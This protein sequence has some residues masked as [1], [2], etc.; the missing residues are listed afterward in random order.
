MAG[1]EILFSIV[2]VLGL[3]QLGCLI[4][5]DE[6][7]AYVHLWRWIGHVMGVAPELAP[8]N[9]REA[10]RHGELIDLTS[11]DPDDDS[12]ALVDAL[13]RS[14]EQSPSVEVRKRAGWVR[15]ILDALVHELVG[16]D[17]ATRL[18]VPAGPVRRAL[19]ALR[20]SMRGVEVLR[21]RSRA[22][23]DACVRQGQIYWARSI[24][25]GLGGLPLD[26]SAVAPRPA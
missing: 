1:T 26:L 21:R 4:E 8:A 9:A 22:V 20:A 17:L 16:A 18:G 24:A 15:P 25:E 11:T 10:I 14:T 13:L 23:E 2:L 19:P 6:A 12:R 5:D 7:D 3:R